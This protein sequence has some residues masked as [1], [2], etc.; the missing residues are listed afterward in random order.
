MPRSSIIGTSRSGEGG[1]FSLPSSYS[2]FTSEL[3]WSL[4]QTRG[5]W[6]NIYCPTGVSAEKR[7]FRSISS[8]GHPFFVF[9]SSSTG[10]RGRKDRLG[11]RLE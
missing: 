11:R 3:S 4:E 1:A 10:S 9:V 5:G 6:G 2:V 7:D 8:L